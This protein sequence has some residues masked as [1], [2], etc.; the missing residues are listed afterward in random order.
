MKSADSPSGTEPII[1]SL[2]LFNFVKWH[3]VGGSD[4]VEDSSIAH[5]AQGCH[6]SH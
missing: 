1:L 5:P 2:C 4:K 6:V 3:S